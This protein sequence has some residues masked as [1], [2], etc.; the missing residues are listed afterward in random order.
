MSISSNTHYANKG[1]LVSS[2]NADIAEGK[3]GSYASYQRQEADSW[4]LSPFEKINN[5]LKETNKIASCGFH[6][7]NIT[8]RFTYDFT[9]KLSLYLRG[10]YYNNKTRRPQ[11]VYAYDMLHETYSY[12][13]G[14]KY[15]IN[16]EAY[17]SADYYADYFIST[18][19][20]FKDDTKNN[21]LNGDEQIRKR[22]RFHDATIKGIFNINSW[23]KL[24]VGSE[25]MFDALKSQT[26]N[27]NKESA[28]TIALFA[29]DE[30]KITRSLQALLGLRYLYHENFRSYA[31][32]NVALMYKLN[33]F[34]FRGSYATGF[35][36][37]TLSEMYATDIAKTTD[38]MTI[39]NTNLKPE[40]SDYFSF[41][42]EYTHSRFAVSA[43]LFYNKIRDMIDYN[44]IA[45]GNEALKQYGYKEVRQRDNIAKAKVKGISLSANGYIGAGFSMNIGFSHLNTLDM[46]TDKPIDKSIKN[47]T[48]TGIL[49]QHTWRKILSHSKA[50]KLITEI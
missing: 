48:T 31:T 12:G 18:Y 44:T 21:A 16:R 41:N 42:T 23:N 36:T 4:Q 27:I 28:Y 38:R 40:K 45:Q 43:N 13:I 20:F 32:P 39:G 22:T 46:E 24:S 37:P 8:Q 1:R 34:N 29:Q 50:T 10:G 49:W 47:A 30:I 26:D 14:S 6:S 5:T 3:F 11:D 25:Y 33:H 7:D 2:V 35:R 17:I 19:C 9:D 15:I